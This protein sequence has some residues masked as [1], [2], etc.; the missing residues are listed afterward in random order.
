[1]AQGKRAPRPRLRGPGSPDVASVGRVGKSP[2]RTN[3]AFLALAGAVATGATVLPLVAGRSAGVSIW[4]AAIGM[5]GSVWVLGRANLH[6]L[7]A[8][9]SRPVDAARF[10]LI[11]NLLVTVAWLSGLYSLFV[12]S[13]ELSRSFT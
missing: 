9:R 8:R 11:L 2:T 6:V 1:M 5:F 13:Y 4:A 7:K 3:P 12:A 10:F